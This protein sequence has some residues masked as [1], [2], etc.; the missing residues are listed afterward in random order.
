MTIKTT[1]KTGEKQ[2]PTKTGKNQKQ[3]MSKPSKP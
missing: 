1:T 3:K 2:K